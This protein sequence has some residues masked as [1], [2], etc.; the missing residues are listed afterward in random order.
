MKP[1]L[2][3]RRLGRISYA[4]GLTLQERLVDQ[5]KRGVAGDTPDGDDL[6]LALS[7]DPRERLVRRDRAVGTTAAS[8]PGLPC[9]RR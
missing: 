9:S 2:D 4:E 8:A 6:V 3:I 7:E 1:P 5:R